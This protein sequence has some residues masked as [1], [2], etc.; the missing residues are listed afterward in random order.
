MDFNAIEDDLDAIFYNIVASAI[1]KWWTFKL[2]RWL[3]RYPLIT[4]E[5]FGGF[6]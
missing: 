5:P 3:Q 4:F 2:L 6:G 1:S